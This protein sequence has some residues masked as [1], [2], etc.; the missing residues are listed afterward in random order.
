MRIFERWYILACVIKTWG[1][2]ITSGYLRLCRLVSVGSIDDLYPGRLLLCCLLPGPH[3][4]FIPV[5]HWSPA[6]SAASPSPTPHV[7]PDWVGLRR[8]TKSGAAHFE[9]LFLSVTSIGRNPKPPS[10]TEPVIDKRTM[11]LISGPRFYQFLSMG[12][13]MGGCR[14]GLAE[15][16]SINFFRWVVIWGVV[17]LASQRLLTGQNAPVTNRRTMWLISGPRLC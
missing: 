4:P 2:V 3:A 14:I 1:L 17:E 15:T 16:V 13:H 10:Q 12:C 5:V 11:R 6:V 7:E 9:T 8:N